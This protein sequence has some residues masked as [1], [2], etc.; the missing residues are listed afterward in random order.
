MI[1]FRCEV[2]FLLNVFLLFYF[3]IVV[4]NLI[5]SSVLKSIR[6]GVPNHKFCSFMLP[7]HSR[8][9]VVN[10]QSAQ[11][12]FFVACIFLKS[13]IS[14]RW[15]VRRSEKVLKCPSAPWKFCRFSLRSCRL[16]AVSVGLLLAGDEAWVDLNV[17]SDWKRSSVVRSEDSRACWEYGTVSCLCVTYSIQQTLS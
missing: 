12:W 3:L 11:F 14:K 6:F 10:S 9:C 13:L 2:H 4:F 1:M 15:A 17:W 7:I 8:W 16:Q 5:Y